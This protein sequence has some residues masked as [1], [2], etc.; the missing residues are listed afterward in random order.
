MS[1]ERTIKAGGPSLQ[2]GYESRNGSEPEQGFEDGGAFGLRR[3]SAAL[4]RLIRLKNVLPE[5]AG[6]LAHSKTLR[7]D[8]GTFG[9]LGSV[10]RSEGVLGA[11]RL[12]AN[13]RSPLRDLSGRRE[14]AAII[15]GRSLSVPT[16]FTTL[17]TVVLALFFHAS[18]AAANAAN[19]ANAA[20]DWR[21]TGDKGPRFLTLEVFVDSGTTPLAAYQ[22]TVKATQGSV[23][24]AGIEGGESPAFS[25]PPHYDPKALQKDHVVLAAFSTKPATELPRGRTRVATIH[26][27]VTGKTEPKFSVALTTAG[28]VEGT[29]INATADAKEKTPD[30]KP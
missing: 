23:K 27:Q 13:S 17:L 26:L 10:R 24:I 18:S 6:A 9:G 2:R 15:H 16:K 28:T 19:A 7:D 21:T 8:A 14:S 22:L 1:G 12:A 3:C 11:K 29:K 5:S 30:E 4:W 25:E 20:E